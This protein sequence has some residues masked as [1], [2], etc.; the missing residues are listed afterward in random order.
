M[1]TLVLEHGVQLVVGDRIDQSAADRDARREGAVGERERLLRVDEANACAK[2][3]ALGGGHELGRRGQRHGPHPPAQADGPGQLLAHRPHAERGADRDEGEEGDRGPQVLAAG[4]QRSEPVDRDAV[5][6]QREQDARR[7]ADEH[8]RAEGDPKQAEEAA[9]AG[10]EPH[11]SSPSSRSKR[12]STSGSALA[13]ST[14][15]AM[16]ASPNWRMTLR[17]AIPAGSVAVGS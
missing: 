9:I 4:G 5:A 3:D 2:A 1:V 11:D 6:E 12:L 13:S 7:H 8:V 15:C 10:V 14:K 17:T 16:A